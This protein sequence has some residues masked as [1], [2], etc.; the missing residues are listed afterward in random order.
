VFSKTL[1][2]NNQVGEGF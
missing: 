2:I 1:V